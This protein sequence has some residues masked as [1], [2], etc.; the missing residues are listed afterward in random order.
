MAIIKSQVVSTSSTT[1]DP[2]LLPGL[3][4]I[5]QCTSNGCTNATINVEVSNDRVA[6][7]QMGTT[8]SLATNGSSGFVEVTGNWQFGR[9]NVTN[10]GGGAVTCTLSGQ[11][12]TG[13]GC[14]V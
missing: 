4:K 2:T 14:F 10:A 12:S 5:F 13:S 9:F 11:I 1:T 8:I 6:W 7:I 3:S